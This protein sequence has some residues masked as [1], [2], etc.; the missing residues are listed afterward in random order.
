[1]AEEIR[2]KIMALVRLQQLEVE[3]SRF[4]KALDD[5]PAKLDAL[6]QVLTAARSDFETTET[7]LNQLRKKY[8]D[9]EAELQ[10]METQ[11][12]KSLQKLDGAASNKE[13]Q[14]SLTEIEE[15]RKKISGIEDGLLA[16]LDEIEKEERC[17]VAAK[18]FFQTTG[19]RIEKERQE[20]N[21]TEKE[22]S[23]DLE[24]VKEKIAKAKAEIETDL[25]KRFTIVQSQQRD[26]VAISPAGAMQC[27]GCHLNLPPQM[28]NELQRCEE[29]MFCPNCQRF[30]Y[31]EEL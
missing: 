3:A 15:G 30:I 8:R 28:F 23:R 14:S 20:V 4:Q 6:E 22:L 27:R 31:W 10:T 16:D 18:I 2:E 1:M 19:Q 11:L 24:A 13:Y 17:V 29:L 7:S 12:Q 25:L 9:K 26:R 5:I 21:Q